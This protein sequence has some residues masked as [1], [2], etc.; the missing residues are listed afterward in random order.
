M[1]ITDK[2]RF[3][4]SLDY[5]HSI[6][7]AHIYDLAEK[8]NRRGCSQYGDF[9][10]ESSLGELLRR[11]DFLPMHPVLFGGFPDAERKMVGFIP[12]YEDADFPISVLSLSSPRLKNLSHRDFLGSIMGL[13]IKREKCGDI[14]M[15]DNS[16][17][18]LLHSDIADFVCSSLDKVGREGVK[19]VITELC[20]LN[21]PEKKFTAVSGTVASLRLDAIVSLFAGKGRSKSGELISGGLVFVNG[22]AAS[23]FDMHLS[24]GDTVSVRGIGRATLGVGG[25]SKKDRIFITLNKF[26]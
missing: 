16:C 5:E 8:A 26:S 23:K 2:K 7:F 21:I 1:G 14:I 17:Q 10:S 18:I 6:K 15:N 3:L 11:R 9:L 4:S 20:D 13:G 19:A 24:D 12:E 22:I 25:H